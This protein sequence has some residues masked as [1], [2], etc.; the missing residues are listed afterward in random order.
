[1]DVFCL[2][3]LGRESEQYQSNYSPRYSLHSLRHFSQFFTANNVLINP[4]ERKA[5]PLMIV[6][7]WLRS[8][9][10]IPSLS[11]AVPIT[12]KVGAKK[13]ASV[14]LIDV[15]IQREGAKDFNFHRAVSLTKTFISE[16]NSRNTGA[17]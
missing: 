1:M 6:E 2:L 4:K 5:A 10:E 13:G 12:R 9:L 3:E 8:D 16:V 11:K 7:V 15:C 17:V 14:C